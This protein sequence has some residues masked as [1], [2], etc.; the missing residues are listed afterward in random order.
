MDVYQGGRQKAKRLKDLE[1]TKR[2]GDKEK[3]TPGNKQEADTS[4]FTRL[5]RFTW[6]SASCLLPGV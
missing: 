6:V 2:R 1:E 4:R 3:K 5:P